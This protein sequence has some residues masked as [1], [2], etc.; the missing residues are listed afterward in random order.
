MRTQSDSDDDSESEK[1]HSN[2]WTLPVPDSSVAHCGTVTNISVTT[3]LSG[4][5]RGSSSVKCIQVVDMPREANSEAQRLA[6]RPGLALRH[7]YTLFKFVK[8]LTV[9]QLETSI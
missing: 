6:V 8:K 5:G 4:I 9:K 3:S 7:E 1:C 2:T